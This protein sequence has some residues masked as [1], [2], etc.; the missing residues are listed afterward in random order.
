MSFRKYLY[1]DIFENLEFLGLIIDKEGNVITT[2]AKWKKEAL[3]NELAGRVDAVGMNY[4]KLCENAR[5]E[6]REE[7]LGIAKGIKEVLKGERG[8]FQRVY[9][10]YD[11]T[12]KKRY[13]LF[14]IQRITRIKPELFLILHIE[15]SH[16]KS[17]FLEDKSPAPQK[18][19]KRI[20]AKLKHF[21]I[22]EEKFSY[23]EM[24]VLKLVRSGYTSKEISQVLNMSK[25]TVDFYRKRIREKLG[26]KGRGIS[27][28]TFLQQI[29]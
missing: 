5:G 10:F 3:K 8:S 12:G 14:F 20:K 15:V 13:F 16:L 29:D 21:F 28:K 19:D 17:Y 9:S 11:E 23:K 26:I 1:K 27:L 18:E 2:N 24:Q 4:L 25:D 7:A 22:F 6:G